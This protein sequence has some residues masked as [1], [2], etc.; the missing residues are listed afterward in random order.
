MRRIF[1]I[2]SVLLSTVMLAQ[3]RRV[4]LIIGNENYEGHF[5]RL[6]TPE[7]DANAMYNVLRKLGFEAIIA[8]NVKRD[9][10]SYYIENFAK[11]ANGAEISLF[12]YS[13][14]AGIGK[15]DEYFLAPSGSYRSAETLIEDCY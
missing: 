12:Y 10:M 8:K 6:H 11:L 13:G 5:S 7:N 3:Q 4:A 2:I 1:L 9:S 15:N 14:H